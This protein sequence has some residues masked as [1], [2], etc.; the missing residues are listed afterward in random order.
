MNEYQFKIGDLVERIKEHSSSPK[1]YPIGY[2]FIIH[3]ISKDNCANSINSADN[4]ELRNLKLFIPEET[5]ITN[6][7]YN[8]SKHLNDL[9]LKLN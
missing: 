1:K 5:I 8:Y 2:R 7:D 6:V 3:T 9:L 4:H